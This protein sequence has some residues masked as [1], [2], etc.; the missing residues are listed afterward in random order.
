MQCMQRNTFFSQLWY[1]KFFALKFFPFIVR[2]AYRAEIASFIAQ[3]PGE[4][5]ANSRIRERIE[6][7]SNLLFLIEDLYLTIGPGYMTSQSSLKVNVRSPLYWV[8][9]QLAGKIKELMIAKK[10]GWQVLRSLKNQ[11]L[12]LRFVN[13]NPDSILDFSIVFRSFYSMHFSFPWFP[14][15]TC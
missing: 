7:T 4:T 9:N 10:T 15:S 3:V 11:V 5:P 12:I 14:W 13:E 6:F 8:R 1:L 2:N